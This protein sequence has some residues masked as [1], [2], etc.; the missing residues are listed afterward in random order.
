[1]LGAL[2]KVRGWIPWNILVGRY[3]IWLLLTAGPPSKDAEVGQSLPSK[4]LVIS[5]DFRAQLQQHLIPRLCCYTGL[6]HPGAGIDICCAELHK[7]PQ[8]FPPASPGP[9]ESMCFYHSAV[10]AHAANIPPHIHILQGSKMEQ[11]LCS[12]PRFMQGGILFNDDFGYQ[13]TQLQHM[14]AISAS[15]YWEMKNCG[16]QP[17][18]HYSEHEG[19]WCW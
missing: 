1:M 14:V 2:R 16:W 3:L 13:W 7:V 8:P 5:K 17:S 11:D 10:F 12:H 18:L 19:N 4:I 15:I 6:S 9:S